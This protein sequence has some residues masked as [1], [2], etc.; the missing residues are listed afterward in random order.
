MRRFHQVKLKVDQ[1][2]KETKKYQ[3]DMT[4]T[5][6]HTGESGIKVG[7]PSKF[8]TKLVN[9]SAKKLHGLSPGIFKPYAAMETMMCLR[10]FMLRYFHHIVLKMK[11]G[12]QK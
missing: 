5:L 3:N 8:F 7:P 9:K 4:E 6:I 1:K 11:N 10:M 2:T 12:N